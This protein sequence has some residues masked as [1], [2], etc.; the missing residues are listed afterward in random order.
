MQALLQAAGST[1]GAEASLAAAF[2][3]LKTK[4]AGAKPWQAAAKGLQRFLCLPGERLSI[5]NTHTTSR[6]LQYTCMHSSMPLQICRRPRSLAQ[7][8]LYLTATKGLLHFLR[9]PGESHTL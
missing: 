8:Q 7:I 9:L 1:P 2:R 6:K 3:V 4:N 5:S